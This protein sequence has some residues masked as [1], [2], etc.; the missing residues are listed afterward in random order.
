MKVRY[1]HAA[2][3]SRYLRAVPGDRK[4]DGRRAKNAEVVRVVR[5]LPKVLT[6]EDEILAK[7]LLHASME[8]VAP[9][10]S[11]RRWIQGGATE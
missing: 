5:V 8:F 9:A 11:Q 4:C 7:R 1:A 3:E 10:R 6:R 2:S